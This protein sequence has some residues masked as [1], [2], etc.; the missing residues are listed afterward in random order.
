M[1]YLPR[2]GRHRSRDLQSPC[3][4]THRR[5]LP[6]LRKYRL[7]RPT[8]MVRASYAPKTPSAAHAPAAMGLEPGVL[9]TVGGASVTVRDS[10][11]LA[12]ARVEP[13]RRAGEGSDAG[14]DDGRCAC[15]WVAHEGNDVQISRQD[16]GVG[17]TFNQRCVSGAR[18]EL[19]K[20]TV[21][22]LRSVDTRCFWTRR[23][24]ASSLP[25]SR[26]TARAVSSLRAAH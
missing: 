6:R 19:V 18:E 11:V 10:L 17:G 2:D 21:A 12:A 22:G 5:T 9:C 16:V 26:W 23:R 14:L 4:R 20:L 13:P 25:T 15:A 7:A 3:L 24:R 1:H 8:P